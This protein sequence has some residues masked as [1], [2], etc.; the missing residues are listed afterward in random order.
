MSHEIVLLHSA[1]G[2]RPAILDFADCLRRA[3]H[4]VH[5]PDIFDGQVFSSVEEGVRKRDALGIPELTRRTWAAVAGLPAGLV[6]IGWSMGAAAAELL[7]ATRPG[8]KAAVLLHAVLPLTVLVAARWPASVPVQIHYA[9]NDPWVSEAGLQAFQSDV[10]AA[11]SRIDVFSYDG[12]IPHMFDDTGLPGH[13]PDATA[14]M[15]ERLD[16]FLAQL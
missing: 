9:K 5:T 4:R 13:A 11:G 10:A 3:G 8:A 15:R 16:G 12:D 2:L 1:L 6:F 7:A 14:L